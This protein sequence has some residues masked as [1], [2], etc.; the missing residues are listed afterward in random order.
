LL[1]V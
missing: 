1:C